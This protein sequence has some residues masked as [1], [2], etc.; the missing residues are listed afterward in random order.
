[1]VYRFIADLTLLVH[2]AFIVFVVAGAVVVLRYP[3]LAWLHLPAATWGAYIEIAGRVCPLTYLENHLRLAAGQQGYADSFIEHYL[4][5]LIYPAGLTHDLQLWLAAI[6]IVVNV[7]LYGY[8]LLRRRKTR[9][10][11]P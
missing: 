11:P 4:V 8:L 3:R 7:L 9:I 5:P 6:V 1:M 10:K 2:L